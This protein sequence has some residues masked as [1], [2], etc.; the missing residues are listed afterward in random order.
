MGPTL[1]SLRSQWPHPPPREPV[2]GRSERQHDPKPQD[3]RSFIEPLIT[4]FASEIG[5]SPLKTTSN[6]DLWK[7]MRTYA[8]STGVPCKDGTH[9]WLMF[10][11]CFPHHPFEVQLYIWIYSWLGLL[12]D[13]E[14]AEYLEDF[15]MFH[16]RFCA[17]E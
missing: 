11:V 4:S 7:A 14:A 15:S 8:D 13:D 16:E 5:Y 9:S 10:K 1:S 6:D 2:S 3:L 12:L 17:D